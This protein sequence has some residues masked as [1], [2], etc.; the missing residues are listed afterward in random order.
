MRKRIH[1]VSHDEGHPVGIASSF[2]VVRSGGDGKPECVV[3]AHPKILCTLRSMR[4]FRSGESTAPVKLIFFVLS[5]G[6]L[7]WPRAIS[8]APGNAPGLRCLRVKALTSAPR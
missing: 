4:D 1:H 7:G 8:T 3:H 6:R 5:P 2:E